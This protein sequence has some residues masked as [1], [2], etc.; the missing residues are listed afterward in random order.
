MPLLKI[1]G[2]D[3]F[4]VKTRFFKS[5]EFERYNNSRIDQ[6]YYWEDETLKILGSEQHKDRE[7]PNPN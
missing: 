2:L 5:T 4:L 1:L 3:Y 6:F 7:S